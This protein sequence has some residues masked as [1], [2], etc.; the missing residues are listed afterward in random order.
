MVV[1][2]YPCGV[3]TADRVEKR[4]ED[5]KGMSVLAGGEMRNPSVHIAASYRSWYALGKGFFHRFSLNSRYFLKMFHNFFLQILPPKL[6]DFFRPWWPR[7]LSWQC[8]E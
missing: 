8:E 4:S 6:E 7:G 1:R 3:V 2:E 5:G